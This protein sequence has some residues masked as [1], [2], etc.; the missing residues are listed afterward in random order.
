MCVGVRVLSVVV[1]LDLVAVIPIQREFVSL[2]RS[3]FIT[4]QRH[5]FY[6]LKPRGFAVM[7]VRVVVFLEFFRKCIPCYRRRKFD[8][9]MVMVTMIDSTVSC[10][11]HHSSGAGVHRT[12]LLLVL[13][14]ALCCFMCESFEF[15]HTLDPV[16][17]D[18]IP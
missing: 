4:F 17:R 10:A 18:Q 16:F 2:L 6:E 8:I 13:F 15:P 1:F 3:A 5:C 11:C 12:C 9:I 14:I 7:L